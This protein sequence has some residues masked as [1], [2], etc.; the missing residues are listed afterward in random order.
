MKVE[1]GSVSK[2]LISAIARLRDAGVET[3]QL[4]SQL[5]MAYA[6]GCSRLDVVAHPERVLTDPQLT[7]LRDMLQRRA[8]RY[9]LAYILGE[10]EFFGLLLEVTPAV[11]IPRPET[12]ILVEQVLARVGDDARIADIGTGSGAIAVAMAVNLRAARIWATDTSED[13]LKVARANAEKH[14]V[15]ERVSMISGDLLE[16]LV[17]K[18]L[19]FDA[20]VSNPPYIPSAVIESLEPEVRR[21]P[22][23]ALDGGADGLD[24]YRG[25]FPQAIACTKLVAVE[26]GIGQGDSVADIAKAAGFSDVEIVRDLAGIER[27]AIVGF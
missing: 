19:Q 9:P 23:G 20:V 22:V 5:L 3:P 18:G 7:L 6:L 13:A 25:L 21:E 24:A 2:E 15:S 17:L 26:F 8:T 27:V 4:D 14:A 12:E 10:K 16:P 11:L 1:R